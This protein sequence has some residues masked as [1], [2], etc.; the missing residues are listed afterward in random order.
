MLEFSPGTVIADRYTIEEELEKGPVVAT[1][2]AQDSELDRAVVLEV[3]G[4]SRVRDW[5]AVELFERE[6]RILT[7]LAHPR[8]PPYMEGFRDERDGIDA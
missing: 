8:I 6:A 4:L 7:E 5:K 2:R 1:Y 3:L